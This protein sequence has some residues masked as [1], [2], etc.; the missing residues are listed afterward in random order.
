[1]VGVCLL[2]PPNCLSHRTEQT[3]AAPQLDSIQSLHSA[4][5]H[6]PHAG[7]PYSD[8]IMQYQATEASQPNELRRWHTLQL[9]FISL[10]LYNPLPLMV[11][12]GVELDAKSSVGST[13]P[14][15]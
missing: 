5:T 10:P 12:L 4:D 7:S 9:I 13:C 1:M 15:M 14:S 3:L 8:A 11:P 2:H 6:L